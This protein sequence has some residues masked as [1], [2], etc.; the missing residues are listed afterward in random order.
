M[1]LIIIKIFFYFSLYLIFFPHKHHIN[2]LY[3]FYVIINMLQL[4]ER[5]KLFILKSR[6]I[7]YFDLIERLQLQI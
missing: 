4:K 5:A 1:I 6:K 7:K 2:F 3:K